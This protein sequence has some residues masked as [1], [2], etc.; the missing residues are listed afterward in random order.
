MLDLSHYTPGHKEE[1][2]L[3]L[4]SPRW[5]ATLRSGLVE[6]VKAER[7]APGAIRN[8]IDTVVNQLLRFNEEKAKAAIA[9]GSLDKDLLFHTL[10]RWPQAL[11]GQDPVL[12]FLGLNLTADCNSR[13]RCLYCN[14][15]WIDSLVG[16]EG[17]K[18]A[19]EEVTAP[20]SASGPYVYITGGEPLLLGDDLWGDGG[21]VRYA[22]GRGAG[23][24]VNTN[25]ALLSP[26]VALRFIKAGLARLHISLDAADRTV[27]D[28]LRGAGTFDRVV[29]AISNVQLAR[30]LVGVS[31]PVIHTNCVLTRWNIDLFPQLLAF[32]LEKHKQTG[33]RE[34]PLF[35]DLL[36]HVIPVGGQSNDN[37]RPSDDE[38]RRFYEEVWPRACRL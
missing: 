21:L 11:D 13:P 1:L 38:F 4:R 27:H 22:T 19:V 32:L 2:Q 24:N 5:Q 6:E 8:F 3:L 15:P 20:A 17:W 34:D 14:Q 23:V 16:V 29:E 7:L 37:L 10:S 30:D 25:A 35:N 12:S 26:E 18:R 28:A 9:Q 31:Y 33:E 36:P